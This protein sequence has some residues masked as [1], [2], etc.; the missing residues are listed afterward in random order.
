MPKAK[1]PSFFKKLA[2]GAV[3]FASG[4]AGIASGH[5]GTLM[6]P[7]TFEKFLGTDY[8]MRSRFEQTEA[9][10]THLTKLT[11]GIAPTSERYSRGNEFWRSYHFS[12]EENGKEVD[13]DSYSL[14]IPRFKTEDLEH[15]I[16]VYGEQGDKESAGF[17]GITSFGKLDLFYTAEEVFSNDSRRVGAG[18]EYG[19]GE[20]WNFGAGVDKVDTP[21]GDTTYLSGKAVWNINKNHQTGIGARLANN[22]IGT[23]R[24]AAFFMRHGDVEWGNRTYAYYD[25]KENYEALTFQ[26]I[27]AQHPTFGKLIHGNAFVGRNQGYI[28]SPEIIKSPATVIESPPIFERSKK[29]W[30]FGAYGSLQRP[31]EE[32]KGYLEADLGYNFGNYGAYVFSKNGIGGVEDSVGVSGIVYLGKHLKLE[33]SHES[34]KDGNDRD[35]VGISAFLPLGGK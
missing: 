18:I 3:A 5:S 30:S 22:D 35:W 23:N 19:Y 10:N 34:Y 27:F 11:T 13:W 33:A 32:W 28:L 16:H 6:N 24:A 25:W 12:G 26:T 4:L 7:V 8:T 21:Q 15:S 29:G 17:E 20:T 2:I 14:I 9:E 1:K 31:D